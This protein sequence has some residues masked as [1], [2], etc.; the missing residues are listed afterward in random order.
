MST[1]HLGQLHA[2]YVRIPV[3]EIDHVPERDPAVIIRDI[4]IQLL[5]LRNIQDSLIDPVQKLGLTG[6]VHRH[7]RPFRQ[8]IVTV[9]ELRRVDLLEPVCDLR[10]L[11]DLLQSGGNDIVFT[12]KA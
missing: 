9:E 1:V 8:A 3:S 12:G 2:G 11:Y 7:G 10:S 4:P 6:V 5:L